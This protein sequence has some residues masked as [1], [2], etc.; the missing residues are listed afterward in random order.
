MSKASPKPALT[1][2]IVGHR[3]NRLPAETR[4]K[5]E[6]CLISMLKTLK[7]AFEAS[8]RR[9][10]D[11]FEIREGA[12]TL[13]SALA[14][15]ADTM[16]ARAALTEGYLLDAIL[17]FPCDQYEKDFKGAELPEFREL[18]SRARSVL[19]LMGT[20]A[21]EGK[22]YEAAGIAILDYSDL[23]IAVWDGGP[24]T[25]RGGTLELISEAGRRGLPIILIDANA[26]TPTIIRW[27][28]LLSG[29]RIFT[30]IDDH[31]ASLFEGSID[32]VVEALIRPPANA[33]ECLGLKRFLSDRPASCIGHQ[34]FPWLMAMFFVRW[35][36]WS[37]WR[38]AQSGG[39]AGPTGLDAGR[40]EDLLV[41]AYER[42]DAVSVYFSQMF[43]SAFVENFL[44][45]AFAVVAAAVSLVLKPQWPFAL[46]ELLLIAW[47]LH[48]TGTGLKRHWQQR[49]IQPR[50]VA[51]RLRVA[52]PMAI[53]GT[54][55]LGPYGEASTWTSW[56]TRAL[57]RQACITPG[58]VDNERLRQVR[59][60][61]VSLLKEQSAY[62]E[63]TAWR[64]SALSRRMQLAGKLLLSAT[65]L[66][67]L[68]HLV[69]EFRLLPW[70]SDQPLLRDQLI[71]LATALP[72]VGAALFGIRTIGDFDSAAKRAQRMREEL[73]DL[74]RILAKLPDEFHA[75]R[76]FC[77][78]VEDVLLGDVASWRLSAESRGLS[79][80]G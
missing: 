2:G 15:G 7:A 32:H 75:L 60:G 26:R 14:E 1:V 61:L 49:W 41:S 25:G 55:P 45:S 48:S 38:P 13:V 78:V 8:W 17:P 46:L 10:A 58:C 28:G 21:N 9:Y 20:R 3:S 39:S 6:Q 64:F 27:H 67:V 50:E 79:V 65:I 42:A 57:L 70:I 63:L 59:S 24:S 30:H 47:V 66:A 80:P 36:R 19:E 52:V 37:D 51:E 71:M 23:L 77:H 69:A 16:T 40:H 53:L 43:R 74:F 31:P 29:R 56:Y 11:T 33:D 5:V 18:L 62:Q 22:S 12:L 35:P 54:R 68:A 73:E 34:G 72:A 76:A 4:V 44:F